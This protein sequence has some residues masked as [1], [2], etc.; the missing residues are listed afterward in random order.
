MFGNVYRFPGCFIGSTPEGPLRY[1]PSALQSGL[2]WIC[3]LTKSG[4]IGS[5]FSS[6]EMILNLMDSDL[7]PG[8]RGKPARCPPTSIEEDPATALGR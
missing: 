7:S 5:P 6:E 3:L 1:P 2:H 4:S 8:A